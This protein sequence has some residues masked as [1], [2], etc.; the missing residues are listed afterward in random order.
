MSASDRRGIACW[1]LDHRWDAFLARYLPTVQ[2][3]AKARS[4]QN[5]VIGVTGSADLPLHARMQ[6]W[7]RRPIGTNEGI[8]GIPL[9]P[10]SSNA[11]T[12][13]CC[14]IKPTAGLKLS[15]SR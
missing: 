4:N 5:H 3:V 1:S 12:G 11:E 14:S 8:F 15:L 10:M 2:E 7:V 6:L 13:F 9:I